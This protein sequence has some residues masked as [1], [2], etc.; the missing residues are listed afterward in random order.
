MVAGR[1]RDQFKN[2]YEG[3]MGMDNSVGID[4]GS[5]GGGV[6]LVEE[7]KRGKIGTTV[8]E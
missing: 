8:M 1:G 6:D 3:P 5:K 7:G 4:R 2:M